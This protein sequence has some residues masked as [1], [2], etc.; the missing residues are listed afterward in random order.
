MAES[1]AAPV[2]LGKEPV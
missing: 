2:L 1:S